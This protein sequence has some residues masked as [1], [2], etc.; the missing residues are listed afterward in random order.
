M[1]GKNIV[2]PYNVGI[3]GNCCTHGMGICNMLNQR[4]DTN[5]VAAYEK[6]PK[7]AEELQSV[8]NQQLSSSYQEV[9]DSPD[10][11]FVAITCDPCDKADMVEQATVRGLHIL[12]NKPLCDNLEN[13]HRIMTAVKT[14]G[15]CFVYDIPMVRLIPVFATLMDQVGTEQ[16]GKIMGYYHLFAMNFPMDFDLKS[17]WP[18]RLD[19][20]EKS[21]GGEMTNMGC[22]AIDYVVSLFGKPTNIIAKWRKNW[23]IYREENVEN[24]GQ[25]VLDYD[26]FYALLDVGKQRLEKKHGHSNLI[27]INFEHQTVTIDA[28]AQVVIINHLV[29]DYGEFIQD[30]IVT[31]SVEQLIGAIEH[32]KY[33]TSS[34]EN[35]V[36]ATEILMA[37]YQSIVEKRLIT[38]PLTSGKNPLVS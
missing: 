7:R 32:D 36:A 4:K 21:G 34:I 10:L 15:V 30:V 23:D 35:A 14:N 11:D 28:N 2:K 27:T 25:I 20:P 26:D 17:I 1:E 6:N 16:Y 3:I 5:V 19:P 33:P 29:Q 8:L 37:A 22:Y 13:A 24:F 9:M 38:L 12:L 18:E 31:G